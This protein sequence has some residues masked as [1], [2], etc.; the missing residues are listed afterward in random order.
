MLHHE[1]RLAALEMEEVGL[2]AI[3]VEHQ[4]ARGF[5]GRGGDAARLQ[6]AGRAP[7]IE[8]AR[9]GRERGLDLVLRRF[10]AGEAAQLVAPR[11]VGALDHVAE[12]EPL[13]RSA[14]RDREPLIVPVSREE[15]VRR[16]LGRAV[17]DPRRVG[18]VDQ[19]VDQLGVEQMHR[20]LVLRD[21]DLLPL[22]RAF[23]VDQR[24]DDLRS[25]D[26]RER[27]IG[28]QRAEPDRRAVC[29]SRLP[30]HARKPRHAVADPAP[31]VVRPPGAHHRERGVD[32][33]RLD[34]AQLVVG[35][36]ELLHRAGREVV[37]HDVELV[38][39]AA[40]QLEAL[41]LVQVERDAPLVGVGVVEECAGVDRET[42]RRVRELAH[43]VQPGGGLDLD[44]I[45][46]E[47]GQHLGDQRPRRHPAEIEHAHA[48]QRQ[49]IRAVIGGHVQRGRRSRRAVRTNRSAKRT[50]CAVQLRAVAA[51]DAQLDQLTDLAAAQT[52]DL[53][54]RFNAVRAERWRGT[55]AEIVGVRAVRRARQRNAAPQLR[56]LDGAEETALLQVD[57]ADQIV[58]GLHR[59]AEIAFRLRAAHQILAVL[60]R[61]EAARELDHLLAVR[62]AVILRG[63]RLLEQRVVARHL[64]VPV[65]EVLPRRAGRVSQIRHP[66]AVGALVGRARRVDEDDLA[67]LKAALLIGAETRAHHRVLEPAGAV[68]L[69]DHP[70]PDVEVLIGRLDHRRGDRLLHAD[71]AADRAAAA[72]ALP[73]RRDR[74]GDRA[75]GGLLVAELARRIVGR[76]VGEAVADQLAAGR[77]RDQ[78][79]GGLLGIAAAED[80]VDQARRILGARFGV[81]PQP[82]KGAA[83]ALRLL[84]R[85]DHDIGALGEPLDQVPGLGRI[86]RQRQRLLALVVEQVAQPALNARLAVNPRTNAAQAIAAGGFDAHHAR[87]EIGEV[88]PRRNRR[89][90]GQIQHQRPVKRQASG[91]GG[92]PFSLEAAARR[93]RRVHTNGRGR[94][95]EQ[96]DLD[97]ARQRALG[98]PP[99][100]IWRRR[101]RLSPASRP[102]GGAGSPKAR[103]PQAWI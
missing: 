46:A 98:S 88:A 83:R 49:R 31:A 16:V 29:L 3:V 89:L 62:D 81:A 39:H 41:R 90:V 59:Q 14:H 55:R 64:R 60:R 36:A 42:A 2:N 8:L 66:L 45:R 40:D 79:R 27:E 52:A 5:G 17:A 24:R 30:H 18:V 1:R 11:Q 95:D 38:E 102:A 70:M 96:G 28:V 53:P 73:D 67:V 101:D 23:A 54:Q 37:G 75:V 103:A 57:V 69:R 21:L 84:D 9:P 82:L 13:A 93:S 72:P 91:H 85:A 22:A 50:V 58:R 61:A 68:A 33:V 25:G 34:R 86:Q 26:R 43:A 7:R 76:G 47:V 80:D 44:H 4:V 63:P 99:R 65:G 35:E 6:Q 97:K 15:A 12:L 92:S 78:V 20:G 48:G 32:Q 100:T 77:H 94:L 87:A 71:D 51:H 19:R 56:V 74:R 10:A